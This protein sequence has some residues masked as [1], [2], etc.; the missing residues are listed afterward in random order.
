MDNQRLFIWGAVALVWFFLYQ[1]WLVDNTVVPARSTAN[2]V[3]GQVARTGVAK[4]LHP[5]NPYERRLVHL[6]VREFEGLETSSEGDGFLKTV[7]V[8]RD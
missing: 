5:M 6:T 1:A 8:C 4:K 7:T 2:E 3:A